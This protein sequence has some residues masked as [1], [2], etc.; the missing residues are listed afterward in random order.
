MLGVITRVLQSISY[1][2]SIP[3]PGIRLLFAILCGYLLAWF[4]RDFL[5]RKG[6]T[7]KHVYFSLTGFGL[8]YFCYGIYVYHSLISILVNYLLLAVLGGTLPVVVVS[9][10]FN[11]GYLVIA[12]L[13]V[14]TDDYDILWTTPQCI[15]CLRLIGLAF[16]LYDGNRPQEEL[17][18][19]QSQLCIKTAPSLLQVT[20]Y[21]FYFGGYFVG[22][23]FA[24]RRFQDFVDEKFLANT[25]G[26]P[27]DTTLPALKRLFLGVVYATVHTIVGSMFTT[28]YLTSQEFDN[29]SLLYKVFFVAVWGRILIARYISVWLFAEG[30]CIL[31]GLAFNGH[32]E[33]NQVKWDGV[34][35]VRLRIY[36]TTWAWKGCI[37]SFNINTS[38][39]AARYI[40]KRLRFL[41]NKMYSQALTLF[42]L[43]LWHGYFIGYF[44]CFFFEMLCVQ[45]E[46]HVTALVAKSP[47]LQNFF[48][49]PV[50]RPIAFVCSRA[51]TISVMGYAV[52]AFTLLRYHR[53]SQVYYSM[54]YIWHWLLF[55]WIPLFYFV[56]N[57]MF[58]KPK[59]NAS[60]E[61]EKTTEEKKT[62]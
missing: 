62:E 43:A 46:N 29:S 3:E 2:T 55:G 38:Q 18:K 20:S 40:Y 11:L 15:M 49:H 22:P 32:D 61:P 23:Q 59:S 12:Y 58:R 24:I 41:G 50:V 48:S 33:Y 14:S 19:E 26:K 42:F 21:T 52:V 5:H 36:E 28:E 56:L 4:Q 10:I 37:E 16:D 17:S 25:D 9:F 54:Y 6:A 45:L 53:F 7:V 27:P 13:V 44:V 8:A 1:V 34:A 35:N 57:P 51:L 60:Q 39:W 47:R 31:S 30:S